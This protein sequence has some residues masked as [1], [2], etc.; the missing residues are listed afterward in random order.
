MKI[1]DQEYIKVICDNCSAEVTVQN[2]Q[3]LFNVGYIYVNECDYCPECVEY[4][5]LDHAAIQ[6]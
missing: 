5:N 4:K 6:Y 1:K 3:T 2:P